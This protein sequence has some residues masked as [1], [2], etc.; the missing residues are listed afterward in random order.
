MTLIIAQN[1]RKKNKNSHPHPFIMIRKPE[2]APL[3]IQC[4]I[5]ENVPLL[6][7]NIP[8]NIEYKFEEFVPQNINNNN[9]KKVE[10][11]NIFNLNINQSY[12]ADIKELSSEFLTD[13]LDVKCKP[14]TKEIVKS[15]KVKN[16]G[17]K[18]WPKPVYLTCVKE[19]SAIHGPSSLIKLKIEKGRETNVEIKLNCK[20][21]KE[22][23]YLSVWQLQN[24]KKEFF[25]Q[26][27]CLK[28]NIE[29]EKPLEIKPEFVNK[30]PSQENILNN[31]IINNNKPVEVIKPEPKNN[32]IRNE[33]NDI[34]DS[35]VFQ[36]QVDELKTAF[37]LRLFDDKTIKKAVMEAKGDV[38]KTL[39]LLYNN[40]RK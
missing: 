2:R 23:S 27:I 35:F 15:I 5:K 13:S 19:D 8:N 22:G 17:E 20:D 16:N 38:D 7:N 4:M 36:C 12:I 10:N 32:N 25:G 1:V 24:D 11:N 28:I 39:Q 14:E 29:K 26:K 18:S 30:G 33:N 3:A 9:N 6:Q 37:D 21:V 40:Q 34:Y 31:K